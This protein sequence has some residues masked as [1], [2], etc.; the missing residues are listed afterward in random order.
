MA[1]LSYP[2]PRFDTVLQGTPNRA[3]LLAMGAYGVERADDNSGTF[4][5]DADGE[6]LTF[7]GNHESRDGEWLYY[8]ADVLKWL[9]F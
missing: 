5:V 6:R 3:L 4:V 2:T 1:R 7:I 8:S 9:G